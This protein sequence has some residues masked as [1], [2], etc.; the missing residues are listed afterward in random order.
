VSEFWPAGLNTLLHRVFP[1]TSRTRKSKTKS[2]MLMPVQIS[3]QLGVAFI[4]EIMNQFR[5]IN[6][7]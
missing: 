1:H 6:P 5:K 4:F 2:S 3:P 7:A